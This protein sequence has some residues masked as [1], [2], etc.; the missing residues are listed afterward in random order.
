MSDI[1]LRKNQHLNLAQD[2]RSQLHINSLNK[3]ILPYRALPEIDFSKVETTVNLFGKKLSQPLIISS[4]TGGSSHAK[5]IN[6]NLA[7][8]CEELK[9]A[10]GV[11]S[12]RIALTNDSAIESFSIVRKLAPTTFIFA[13]MGAVQLNYGHNLDSYKRV[14]EMIKADGLY[15][16]LNPL[17]E[18]IQPEGDTNFSC[19]L[20]KITKLVEQVEIPVFIKEVGHGLDPQSAKLLIGSGVKGIDVAGVGGTSWAWI[21]SQRRS[22]NNFGHWFANL[23]YPT[24]YLIKEIAKFN[25]E[26]LIASGGIRSPIDGIKAHLLGANFYAAAYPFLKPALESPQSVINL[27]NDWQFGLKIGLFSM[28]SQNWQESSQNKLAVLE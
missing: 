19:L 22:N 9:V 13:N 16:H 27:L 21:E 20:E 12:Q 6:S 3:Y 26:T 23:G 4:M 5:T 18:A 8:G 15:L 10:F 25:I 17:Q 14:I 1:V 28:G 7:I 2:P 24:D 11:G